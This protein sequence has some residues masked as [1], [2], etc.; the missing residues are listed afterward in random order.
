[1]RYFIYVA[2]ESE[3]GSTK[4]AS[5]TQNA[6]QS[7]RSP[8]RRF[9]SWEEL[10]DLTYLVETKVPD[11]FGNPNLAVVAVSFDKDGMVTSP[12]TKGKP[13]KG[14]L[15]RL[16]DLGLSDGEGLDDRFY[17]M[18]DWFTGIGDAST[19]W[20]PAFCSLDHRPDPAMVKSESYLYGKLFKPFPHTPLFGCREWA[21]QLYDSERPYIDVTSYELASKGKQ[22]KGY[23]REFIGWARFGDSKPIIGQ[24]EGDWYCLHDC[25]GGDKPGLIPNIK[26]WAKRFDW[27]EPIPPTKVP[28]FPDPPAQTGTYPY[29]QKPLTTPTVEENS[30]AIKPARGSSRTSTQD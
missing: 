5:I 26:S 23:I 20:A 2:P 4:R 10:F 28:T 30:S 27:A 21:Y 6:K 16:R 1:M 8:R 18:A 17:Y 29:S 14:R 15:N 11:L 7:D 9:F 13:L 3:W 12:H 22:P 24:H 19:H 25:P